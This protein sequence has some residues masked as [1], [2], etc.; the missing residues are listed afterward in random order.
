MTRSPFARRGAPVICLLVV[1][2]TLGP[3]CLLGSPLAAF[4]GEPYGM[5]IDDIGALGGKNGKIWSDA[6]VLAFF[7]LPIAAVLD[8]AL[9]PFSLIMWGILSIGGGDD[10]EDHGH[11]HDHDDGHTHEGD[12]DDDVY[13]DHRSDYT[14]G[15]AYGA[16]GGASDR[17]NE[18]ATD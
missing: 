10:E 11:G 5:T 16:E 14:D 2:L 13:T 17:W 15:G 18:R 4:S 1:S 12:D 7:D 8:T 9:L 3:G 6:P